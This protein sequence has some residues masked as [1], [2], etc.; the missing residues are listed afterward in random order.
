MKDSNGK[1]IKQNDKIK[2]SRFFGVGRVGKSIY[3][4]ENVA[5]V[6]QALDE[7]IIVKYTNDPMN[8]GMNNE[9]EKIFYK[10]I[11]NESLFIYI[12]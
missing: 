8:M 9:I 1:V 6:K 5:I 2:I 7:S 10:D 3:H 12:V 4:T 11:D